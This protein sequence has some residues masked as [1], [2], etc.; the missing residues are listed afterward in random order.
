MHKTVE[1]KQLCIIPHF[2]CHRS[3]PSGGAPVQP[4]HHPEHRQSR[5]HH[6]RHP[7][8]LLRPGEDEPPQRPLPGPRQEHGAQGVP[9]HVG[10]H[11]RL[12][13]RFSPQE[14]RSGVTLTHG[15]RN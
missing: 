14:E 5:G 3:A 4:R 11:V 10:G 12:S 8:A 13:V 6:P 15:G 7:G 9:R 1:K 2:C